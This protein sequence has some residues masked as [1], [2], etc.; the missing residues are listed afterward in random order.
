M[1]SLE[2]LLSKYCPSGVP[3]V[4]INELGT[5]TRGKRFVHADAVEEGIPCIHYGELYTF[6]GI[7]TNKARSH[8]RQELASKLRY[9]K[10]NDVIIVGAGE[11]DTDIGVAV[12]YLGD[13]EVA[14]HDACYILRQENDPKYISYC[15][16]TASYHNQI[17]KYVSSGKICA[18]SADGIGK[19]K[20]PIP[21]IEVQRAIVSML[22]V[23]TEY[24]NT[25]IEE[26]SLRQQQYEYY[27]SY[28]LDTDNAIIWGDKSMLRYKSIKEVF[29]RI[30]GTPITAGK[31]K[32]I[33]DPEGN[34]R[35]FAGGKTVVNAKEEA[36]PNANITRVPAVLVQ[37]RGVIDFIYY[38]KPFTFKNEMWAYTADDEVT[39]KYL[40]YILKS[41]VKRFRE[42][43]SG[44]GSL[45]QIALPATEDYKIPLPEMAIQ[46]RIVSILDSF[47]SLCFDDNKGIPAEIALRQKQYD[48]YRDRLLSFKE[49]G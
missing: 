36:I 39:V 45:P 22:D 40:Y 7:S 1:I 17:K 49:V 9:A 21:P 42:L 12:A 3:F 19:A 46:K 18:I 44:T 15:L 4:P 13:E 30:K 20:L 28:V 47:D 14:V 38:D 11:N 32:E 27:S 29:T 24:S 10:K 41:N 31:M 23:F 16:R 35:I 26:L 2:E 5:I 48:Y 8:V 25:L 43:A 33:D 34:I 6:Y 37:S